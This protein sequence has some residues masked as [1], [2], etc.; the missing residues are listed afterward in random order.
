MSKGSLY[1]LVEGNDDERFFNTVLKPRLLQH[2]RVIKFWKYARERRRRTIKFL[3]ALKDMEAAFIFVRDIDSAPSIGV[4]KREIGVCYDHMIP[5]SAMAIVVMEIESWYLAGHADKFLD[6][7]GIWFPLPTTD[8][9]TKEEFNRLI[10][11]HM[12]R[13]EFMSECLKHFA[14]ERGVVR[15]ASFRYF[16]QHWLNGE[17]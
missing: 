12:S 16:M 14:I 8:T 6:E 11:V 4:K 9:L 2:Y 1:V 13:I 15:N 3:R 7:M 5:E 10:P 17:V